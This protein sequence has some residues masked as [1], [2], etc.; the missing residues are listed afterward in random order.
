MLLLYGRLSLLAKL[1]A[2]QFVQLLQCFYY[3]RYLYQVE[4][5]LCDGNVQ[6]FGGDL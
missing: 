1:N 3:V 6:R 4:A 2:G 5:A